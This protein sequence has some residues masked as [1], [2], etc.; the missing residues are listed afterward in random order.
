M[1][2]KTKKGL[3]SWGIKGVLYK[4]YVAA[5]L[6]LSAGRWDWV[7]GWIY[8]GIFLAFDAAS[9]I[10][11]IPRNPDLLLE[12]VRRN[13]DMKSWDKVIMPL[14][15]GLLPL[16]GW[17]LAGLGERWTWGPAVR[18]GLSSA[19]IVLTIMGYALVVWAMAANAFF[20]A[21]VRIQDD[22]GHTVASGGPYRYVRH[23]GYLGAI[24]F[25]FGIPFL[26]A[27]WWA[28]IPGLLSI[29]LYVLRTAL[30][31]QTLIEELPGYQ[32]F[33]SK[34]KYRLIPGIW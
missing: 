32:E 18:P 11:V 26:L 16:F 34:V 24:A 31:D 13:P 21:V 10:V 29:M 17:I 30:E 28:L 6:M 1:D 14:A 15:A 33:T 25:S 12:R 19:G 27:S 9:A 5:V 4:A 8:V 23:P 3:I 7:E 2:T 22:R 20:S